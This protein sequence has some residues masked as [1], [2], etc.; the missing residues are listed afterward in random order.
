MLPTV[1]ARDID[2]DPERLS[3]LC[4]QALRFAEAHRAFRRANKTELKSYAGDPM[5]RRVE[6]FEAEAAREAM[7]LQRDGVGE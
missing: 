1:V 6:Q 2:N 5:M 3:I 7:R 4:V